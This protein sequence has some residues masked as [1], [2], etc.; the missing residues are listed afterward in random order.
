MGEGGKGIW[1]GMQS[2][3]GVEG[4][5]EELPANHL[6]TSLLTCV[7]T[8]GRTDEDSALCEHPGSTHGRQETAAQM[9]LEPVLSLVYP[10][11]SPLGFAK[12]AVMGTV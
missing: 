8:P 1:R 12:G 5:R 9:S 10:K 4:T 2:G 3:H 7:L 6:H 11:A